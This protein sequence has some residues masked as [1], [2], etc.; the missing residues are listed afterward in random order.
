[1]KEILVKLEPILTLVGNQPWAR[2]VLILVLSLIAAWLIGFLISRVISKLVERTETSLDNRIISHIHKPILVTVVLLGAILAANVAE[3]PKDSAK[4]LSNLALTVIISSWTLV[5]MR[6]TR[7]LFL[8]AARRSKPNSMIRDQTLPLFTN[9][10]AIIIILFGIYIIF[11]I[12]GIDMTAWLASAGIIG[13][14]VGFAAKDTLAN[15]FSG[16]FIMAD[17]P[18]K[19]GDY[20]SLDNLTRGKVT[21]IGIRS[22]RILTRDDVEITVPNSI[23]GNSQIINQTGGPHQKMRVKVRVGVAYDSDLDQVE[24]IL[25]DVARSE[26]LVSQYPVPRVRFRTF[27]P[28]S[29]DC[30]LMVWVAEPELSGSVV[31]QLGKAIHKA[32]NAAGI[33]IPFAQQDLY[34]K[35]W[36]A[37]LNDTP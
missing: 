12:W 7:A 32:F 5:T 23:M 36:P 34:I 3:I 37:P 27:G 18:Y 20:I 28:S 30:D 15:L 13:I 21:H 2:A 1:M 33:V 16:V 22:T 8:A 25:L 9:L 11:Q 29:L 19:L 17:S 4:L 35:E 24:S 26:A 10:A 6:I 31:H 14:A